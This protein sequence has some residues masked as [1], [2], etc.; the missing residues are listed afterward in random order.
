MTHTA[1]SLTA[2]LEK[3]THQQGELLR[4]EV[5]RE[6]AGKSRHKKPE[7]VIN[8]H[9]IGLHCASCNQITKNNIDYMIKSSTAKMI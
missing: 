5:P 8:F 2:R 9:Q 1:E 4:W 7:D 3:N 6:Q